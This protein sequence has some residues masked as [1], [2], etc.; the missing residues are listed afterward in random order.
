[1]VIMITI[2]IM[3]MNMIIIITIILVIIIMMMLTI[4]ITIKG[5]A[6]NNK[7]RID[8]D[9]MICDTACDVCCI[10]HG[11]RSTI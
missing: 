6:T 9:H 7:S 2:M 3:I 11:M 1:M 10:I 5:N 4:M 8:D